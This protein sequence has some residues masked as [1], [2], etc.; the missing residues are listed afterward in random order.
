MI[1]KKINAP[2]Q[3]VVLDISDIQSGNYAESEIL[4]L[5]FSKDTTLYLPQA[6]KTQG[7][8][9]IYIACFTE[10]VSAGLVVKTQAGDAFLQIPAGEA[11]SFEKKAACIK[12]KK[13][14]ADESN[15][16]PYNGYWFI[17]AYV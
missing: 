5:V 14:L 6:S 8:P 1:T 16:V 17:E 13:L 2:S 9:A 12:F 7:F 15:A 11:I 4:F 3:S 10:T